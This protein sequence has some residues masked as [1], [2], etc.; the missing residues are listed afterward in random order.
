[1]TPS[2]FI[3]PVLVSATALLLTACGGADGEARR[4]ETLAD[5]IAGIELSPQADRQAPS[6][7]AEAGLRMADP[8]PL[9]V[10]LLTPHELWDARD[11]VLPAVLATAETPAPVVEDASIRADS[12]MVPTR[13]GAQRTIQI[14]AYGTE[15]AARAAWARLAEGPAADALR[16]M[17]PVYQAVE[18]DGRRLVR[19]RIEGVAQERVAG[20]CATVSG[21]DSWCAGA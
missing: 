21:N 18:I 12:A 4:F 10:E 1:M 16:D 8:K 6:S 20:L 13:A 11:G 3:R 15:A 17:A 7:A 2:A 14:G 5:R 9:R 19:L